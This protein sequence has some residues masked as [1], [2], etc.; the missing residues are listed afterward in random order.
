[1]AGRAHTSLQHSPHMSGRES[2]YNIIPAE[3][4]AF[5][6]NTEATKISYAYKQ[7]CIIS[8][9][10]MDTVRVAFAR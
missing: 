5:L 8:D 1:M 3:I 6:M 10:K 2:S 4:L 9:I 7:E